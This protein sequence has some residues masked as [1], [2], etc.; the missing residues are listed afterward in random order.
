[1]TDPQTIELDC[2]PGAIR[3]GDLITGVIKDTGLE[4]KEP[5]SM[6]FGEWTWNY[7][8]VDPDDWKRIQ[9]IVKERITKLYQ[10]GMI[11][12]GSW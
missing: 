2:A 5:V 1:M 10:S 9:K 12:F 3:P 4:S 8:E 7:S 11:R 6:L